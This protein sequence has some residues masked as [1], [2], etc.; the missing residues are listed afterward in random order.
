MSVQSQIDKEVVR[1]Y[2]IVSRVFRFDPR[3]AIKDMA[4]VIARDALVKGGPLILETAAGE[5][6]ITS[7]LAAACVYNWATKEKVAIIAPTRGLRNRIVSEFERVFAFQFP[8]LTL[9]NLGNPPLSY[10]SPIRLEMLLEC[11]EKDVKRLDYMKEFKRVITYLGGD[12]ERFILKYPRLLEQAVSLGIDLNRSLLWGESEKEE[13]IYYD[14]AKQR[15]AKAHILVTGLQSIKNG[16]IDGFENLIITSAHSLGAQW[17]LLDSTGIAFPSLENLLIN[18]HCLFGQEPPDNGLSARSI[19]KTVHAARSVLGSILQ[20]V[21]DLTANP[22]LALLRHDNNNQV[23]EQLSGL[24]AALRRIEGLLEALPDDLFARSLFFEV[25]EQVKRLIS[26]ETLIAGRTPDGQVLLLNGPSETLATPG[27]YALPH[28]TETETVNTFPPHRSLTLLSHVLFDVSEKFACPGITFKTVKK[29]STFFPAQ[30]PGDVHLRL[31]KRQPILKFQ[32]IID[33]EKRKGYYRGL[34]P[35]IKRIAKRAEDGVLILVPFLQDSHLLSA[36]FTARKQSHIV[37]EPDDD[38]A[39]CLA[40]LVRAGDILISADG[41]SADV[42]D[43][44]SD[45][46]I[47]LIPDRAPDDCSYSLYTK[48]LYRKNLH[49]IRRHYAFIKIRQAIEGIRQYAEEVPDI[50]LMDSRLT[51]DARFES[52]LN[53]LRKQYRVS[54][55]DMGRKKSFESAEMLEAS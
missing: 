47:P 42:R 22:V 36:M 1:L 5:G 35:E 29:N 41:W 4:R 2:D 54:V 33:E 53:F 30:L 34:L 21:Q 46:I 27:I 38:I 15:M 28:Q 43:V 26:V 44:V 37:H 52:H 51:T 55:V 32:E 12:F 7:A 49:M 6:W 20:T 25:Q 13:M 9:L 45:I 17:S 16:A 50:W 19:L 48:S 14:L 10:I 31:Y 40:R 24:V 8:D 11:Y 18:I 3:L 39:A 23:R